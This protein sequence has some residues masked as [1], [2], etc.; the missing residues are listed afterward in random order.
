[1]ARLERRRAEGQ[2]R[3]PAGLLELLSLEISHCALLLRE[4][5]ERDAL[6]REQE[7][8]TLGPAHVRSIIAARAERE[9]RF[10]FELGDP[11]WSLLLELYACAL[12]GRAVYFG[13]LRQATGLASAAML[14]WFDILCEMGLAERLPARDGKAR[15]VCA[16]L[17]PAGENAM[18][19]Y[20]EAVSCAG[21]GA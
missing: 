1:V 18:R 9:R 4:M 17:T 16:A 11:A 2:S 14:R 19:D 20:F 3:R 12:E 6:R 8:R 13:D 15:S 21:P 5:A 10:P 7:C